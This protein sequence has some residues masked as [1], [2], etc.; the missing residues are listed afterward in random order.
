MSK[1]GACAQDNYTIEHTETRD[2]KLKITGGSITK[3]GLDVH[4]LKALLQDCEHFARIVKG[5]TSFESALADVCAQAQ[6]WIDAT[7]MAG[8][9]A[10]PEVEQN[11]ILELERLDQG[12]AAQSRVHTDHARWA[13]TRLADLDPENLDLKQVRGRPRPPP[14]CWPSAPALLCP[15]HGPSMS[16]PPL[17]GSKWPRGCQRKACVDYFLV[18]GGIPTG[19]PKGTMDAMLP[20]LQEMLP[21]T[22]ATVFRRALKEAVGLVLTFVPHYAKQHCT[23]IRMVNDHYGPFSERW[24]IW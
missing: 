21:P 8:R 5:G 6:G 1:R 20:V 23:L 3:R 18:N 24:K 14:P 17:A 11:L 13:V 7:D 15:H 19:R 9:P 10:A 22:P 2:G 4:A 16:V 12:R